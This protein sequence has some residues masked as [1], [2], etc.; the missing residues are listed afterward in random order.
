[1]D[2]N[3][4]LSFSDDLVFKKKKDEVLNNNNDNGCSHLQVLEAEHQKDEEDEE[5]EEEEEE[6]N[7]IIINGDDPLDH[8]TIPGWFCEHCPQWPGQA[9]FLKVDKVLFQGKSAYQAMLSSA[10]GKV[11]V[12]DGALQ[13]TEKDECAY[14][15]MITHLP[16]CSIP[17]P[18]KVLVIGGG[19]GGILREIS[20]H[21]SIEQ[22]DI[23]EID[24]M[25][26]DV[27]K[28]YFPEI[29][30]GYK[31]YRVNL[32]IID[33]SAFLSSVPPGS[34]DA[35]IVDAFDPIKP[36]DEVVRSKLFENVAKALKEGGVLCIQAESLWFPSLD[37]QILISKCKQVF[38]G[39]VQ[40][41]WT[42]VP[43]YPSGVIGF[44]L[45]STQGPK[46]VDFKNPINPID[47]NKN[48]GVATQPLKFYNSEA[49]YS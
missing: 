23:C 49:S 42:I 30:V 36:D 26:I 7:S 25:L 19:D 20:R 41:A 28:K 32:H 11:F 21:S 39:S 3:G 18:K 24:T 43:A 9:H 27:Y 5:E 38:K 17:N 48:F 47:S 4:V 37:I 15:E 46:D 1:M 29:A 22:I 10:Y 13:L 14:Q 12:L 33:G 16:L 35:I 34:Y 45:C 44:L 40:Y 2:A 8:P 31:D 6:D